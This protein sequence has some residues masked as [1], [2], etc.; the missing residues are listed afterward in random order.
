MSTFLCFRGRRARPIGIVAR[1]GSAT[2]RLILPGVLLATTLGA[3]AAP[4]A[5]RDERG[6]EVHFQHPPQR[7][8]SL[9]PSLT[10]TV[11]ALNACSHL[12]ATDRYSD[13]PTEVQRLPKVGGGLDPNVEAIVALH[14]DLVLLATS[15]RYASRLEDLGLRVLALEPQ[16][17]A[18]AHLAFTT[19]A[20]VLAVADPERP[21]RQIEQVLNTT[22]RATPASL[23][24]KRVYFE[25]DSSLYAAGA[26]SFIGET[27]AR[28]GM[29][30]IVPPDRGPFPKL[31]PEFV[32]RADPDLIMAGSGSGTLAD[33]MRRPGWSRLR[34][35]REGHL[36]R[37]TATEG[38]VLVRPGPR[39][40]EAA[41]ILGRCLQ[42][43][44][45]KTPA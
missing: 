42:R 37:F 2:L 33:F 22:A 4:V 40:D 24:G 3:Q 44:S 19:I 26:G 14:P 23:R 17:H 10:E 12:V 16:T 1:R 6:R 5:V 8:V 28:L 18:E 7:I 34:A 11:C 29:V 15:S 21:W 38:D 41:R 13:W 27:L 30:N 35:L 36:C 9:L 32:V 25:L 31:N 45:G 20:R 39:L 43:L